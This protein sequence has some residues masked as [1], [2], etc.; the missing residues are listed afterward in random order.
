MREAK[1]APA[2]VSSRGVV[3]GG[4]SLNESDSSTCPYCGCELPPR[5]RA[6]CGKP[7]CKRLHTNAR[8]RQWMAEHPGYRSRYERKNVYSYEH[9]CKLC[10]ETFRSKHS[11]GVYCSRDCR[12]LARRTTGVALIPHP[13]P[14]TM[15][16]KSHPARQTQRKP[17]QFVACTCIICGTPFLTL[18]VRHATCGDARCVEEKRRAERRSRKAY[19]RSMARGGRPGVFSASQWGARLREYD[20]RCAYCGSGDDIQIEHVVPIGGGR[21]GANCIAN[22]VPACAACNRDKGARTPEEWKASDTDYV[23]ALDSSSWPK[24]ARILV[25]TR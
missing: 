3:Q 23:R 15:L 22:V 11:D 14:Y 12:D 24:G 1:S 13:G 8:M 9:T 25:S 4:K 19:E 17:R 5:R 18:A 20:R 10:G 6:H 21:H 2:S 16:P 7:E